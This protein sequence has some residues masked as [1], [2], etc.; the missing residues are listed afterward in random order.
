MKYYTKEWMELAQKL[1]YTGRLKAIPD[2]DYTDEEIQKL[3]EEEEKH[4]VREERE[5]YNEPPFNFL[6]YLGKDGF[7]LTDICRVDEETGEIVYPK[8]KEEALEWSRED[9]ERELTKFEE[10]LPF[11]EEQAKKDFKELYD[12]TLES[13]LE[14]FHK[15]LDDKVDKRLLAL[16]LV[17][18]RIYQKLEKLDEKNEKRFNELEKIAKEIFKNQK[19][20]AKVEELFKGLHDGII[21]SIGEENGNIFIKVLPVAAEKPRIINC[22]DAKLIENEVPEIVNVE[23]MTEAVCTFLYYELYHNQKG[24]EV[25]IMADMNMDLKYITIQCED[26]V[27]GEDKKEAMDELKHS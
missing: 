16:D 10:R 6:E 15:F 18:K 3:Y 25:H 4:F 5:S 23:N 17:P 26:V 27:L 9:Y 11:D 7:E 14:E 24:Y 1:D 20:P 13:S 21:S 19:I 12:N 22:I 8:T 2:K